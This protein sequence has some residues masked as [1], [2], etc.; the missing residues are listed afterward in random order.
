MPQV[1][2]NELQ[3]INQFQNSIQNLKSKIENAKK[4]FLMEEEKYANLEVSQ[5]QVVLNKLKQELNLESLQNEIFNLRKKEA[6]FKQTFLQNIDSNIKNFFIEG[7]FG[8]FL[9]NLIKNLK[10][11]NSDLVIT[12][13]KNAEQYLRNQDFKTSNHIDLLRLSVQNQT[14]TYILD[15]DKLKLKLQEKLMQQKLVSSN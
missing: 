7:S 1:N 8:Q 2:F 10:S 15:L 12:A 5:R 14:K 4:Q 9:D 6:E 13:G 3:E 11:Q